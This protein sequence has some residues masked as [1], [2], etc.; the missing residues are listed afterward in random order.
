MYKKYIRPIL[1]KGDPERVHNLSILIGRI[2][3]FS[4]I[5][6]ILRNNLVVNDKMLKNKVMGIEFDNPI[7]LAAGFDKNAYLIDFMPDIGFGFMEVGSITA[8]PCGGN[9]KPRLH[10]L[11][12]DQGIIVNY[13]LANEGSVKIHERLKGK[14]FRIPVGISI[15]KTNNPNIKGEESVNDYLK[16]FKIIRDIG[17]Y[18]TINISCPNVGDGRSFE[19]CVLLES[20]LNKIDKIRKKE[21]ILLKISPDINKNNLN[22][23][24]KLAEKFKINGFVVSNLTKKR[25]GLSNDLNLKYQG[26]ISGKHVKNKSNALI[27]YIYKK[28]KGKFVIVGCGGVFNGADAYEKIKYGA[29]LI[30][31]ITGMIFEG[32]GVVSKI[33]RELVELLKKG[34]YNNIKEAIG[35][36]VNDKK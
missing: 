21:N 31:M 12:K 16:C 29:S 1:F 13:G 15:A 35:V 28:T 4:K 10:R 24:I 23:I 22:K 33:N 20:L 27:K 17:N 7:G 36:G 25:E 14:K 6:R 32:P 5:S 9:A 18:I 3:A 11:V 19:D 34:G 30:Q 2:L 26:G 8:N